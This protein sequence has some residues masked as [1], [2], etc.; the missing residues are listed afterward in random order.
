MI[1]EIMTMDNYLDLTL[2]EVYDIIT[3][4]NDPW[5]NS[6]QPKKK[7]KFIQQLMDYF[8]EREEYE[9][10][11]ELLKIQKEVTKYELDNRKSSDRRSGNRTK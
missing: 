5:P 7:V 9:R 10:C 11:A 1:R 6:F 8:Q 3:S 4:D 2:R